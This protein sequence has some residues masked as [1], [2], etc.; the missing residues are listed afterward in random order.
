MHIFCIF[1]LH[2]CAYKCIFNAYLCIYFANICIFCAFF[3]HIIFAYLR[4]NNCIY[5]Y[6]YNCIYFINICIFYAYVCSQAWAGAARSVS[7]VGTQVASHSFEFPR[8]LAC[9]RGASPARVPSDRQERVCV[10]VW[11]R[12]CA[13][14]LP[15]SVLG[16][17][18]SGMHSGPW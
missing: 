3:V 2:I 14:R 12:V 17:Y 4:I 8:H 18:A 10:S 13:G 5:N 11:L 1:C 7:P 6:I 15:G 9:R 16:W